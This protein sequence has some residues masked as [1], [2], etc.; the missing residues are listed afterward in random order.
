M[1]SAD[2]VNKEIRLTKPQYAFVTSKAKN[3]AYIAGFGAGKTFALIIKAIVQK[4]NHPNEK[5]WTAF[6]FPTFDLCRVVGIPRFTEQLI[7]LGVPHTTNKTLFFVESPYFGRTYFRS[8][9]RPDSIIGYEVAFSFV[10]ELDR[11]K[12]EKAAEVWG[13]I[14]SR[15]RQKIPG[16]GLNT[17][18]VASTP[19]GFRFCYAMWGKNPKPGYELIK[20][21]TY[22][23][24]HNLQPDYIDSLKAIYASNILAAYLDGEFVNLKSGSVY[25]EF[26]RKL[27]H[28]LETIQP[29]ESLHVGMDFNVTKMCAIIFVLRCGDPH[30]VDE[31]TGIYDTPTMIQSLKRRFP[32]HKIMIYPDASGGARKTTNASQSDL[33]LLKLSGFSV[34]VNS[35]NPFVRDRILSS[36]GMICNSLGIRRF[37]LN[38]DKCPQ[39]LESLE[40]QSYKNGE[41]DKTG[42][43]DHAADAFGYFINYKFPIMSR[44]GT[45]MRMTGI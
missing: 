44:G 4:A 39:L 8:M 25:P 37:R 16:G 36:N 10:D 20:A 23:N 41:P 6:Y 12:H 18:S 43:L 42:G 38:P 29:S 3:P 34:C 35:R 5:L 11:L 32:G 2:I 14:V 7:L 22:S 21:S 33:S 27:N 24:S 45:T 31:L 30:A 28:S 26:D 13:L 9:D 1:D 19:E 17:I 15:N 40:Q